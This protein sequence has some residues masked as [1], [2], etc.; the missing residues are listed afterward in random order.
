MIFPL[1]P[2]ELIILN[3]QM[4][5]LAY[6]LSEIASLLESR[7][8]E[9]NEMAASARIIEQGFANLARRVHNQTTQ[10]QAAHADGSEPAI[11]KSQSA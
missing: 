1:S 5:T 4:S 8:G 6:Q 9:T 11:S 3:R 2:N 10:T 7:L